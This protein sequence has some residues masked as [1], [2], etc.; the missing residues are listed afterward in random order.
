M[1]GVYLFA[2]ILGGGLL[3]LSLMGGHHDGGAHAGGHDA[4]HGAGAGH[5]HG[6]HAV[7]EH[8]RGVGRAGNDLLA[9]FL[10]L[11]FWTFFL[12]FGGLSGVML[13]LLKLP[14]E[15]VAIVSAADGL[16]LGAVAAVV[17]A[18]LSREQ[19]SSALGA[20]DWVGRSGRVTI[21]VSAARQGKIRL[22]LEEEVV[23][24]VASA[25]ETDGEL[26]VGTEVIVV[27]LDEDGVAK[28]TPAIPGKSGAK[29][30]ALTAA[31]G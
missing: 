29:T 7:H 4:A 25:A 21:P 8:A 15:I 16:T 31:K 14:P 10:S 27:A 18:R 20:E 1:F 19:L 28:V 9:I 12:A 22:E 26:A 6:A 13:T 24:L 2:L 17:M 11:R 3:L 23:D 30:P 5:G